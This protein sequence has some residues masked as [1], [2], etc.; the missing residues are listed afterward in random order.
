MFK[1]LLT[2]ARE[3]HL[4]Q[5]TAFQKT[6]DVKKIFRFI[7]LAVRLADQDD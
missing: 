1:E 3:L 7:K 4:T 2:G 6:K 5:I